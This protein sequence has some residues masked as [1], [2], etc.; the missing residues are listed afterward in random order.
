LALLAAALALAGGLWLRQAAPGASARPADVAEKP[1]VSAERPRSAPPVPPPARDIFE[2]AQEPEDEPALPALPAAPAVALPPPPSLAES[3]PPADDGPRLVGLVRQ[4]GAL[5]AA[6][7]VDGEV[8]VV[9][10]GE[11]A[12]AYAVLAIDE[13]EGVRLADA[14]GATLTLAP[15]RE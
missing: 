13:D 12:G 15:P 9:G 11:R 4:A 7:S 2:Y 6:L 8:V 1:A 5:K 14:S 10:A 3:A